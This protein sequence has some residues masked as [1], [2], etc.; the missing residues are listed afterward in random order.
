MNKRG[1][2]HVD[3][4]ISLGIFLIYI[5]SLFL[6]VKPFGGV[7]SNERVVDVVRDEFEE[8]VYWIVKKVPLFVEGCS[9]EDVVKVES[10]GWG[11]YGDGEEGKDVFDGVDLNNKVHFLV[12]YSEDKENLVLNLNVEGDCDVEL[13]AVSDIKGVSLSKINRL[14]EDYLELKEMFGVGEK[15]FRIK[16]DDL[17]IGKDVESNVDVYVREFKEFEVGGNGE[18]KH[19]TVNIAIW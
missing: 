11:V 18:V 5:M 9:S 3:F 7:F 1:V 14:S 10:N 2:S 16:Y 17:I 19:V 8:E 12:F 15:D 6:L 4:V 13:G